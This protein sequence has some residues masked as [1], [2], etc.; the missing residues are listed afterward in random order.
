MG[1]ERGI[2]E[3]K[4]GDNDHLNSQNKKGMI[5]SRHDTILPPLPLPLPLPRLCLCLVLSCLDLSCLVL[6]F[7]LKENLRVSVISWGM[8]LKRESTKCLKL[9]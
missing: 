8:C 7:D 4:R 5:D 2:R 9:R 3:D 6:T 1:G